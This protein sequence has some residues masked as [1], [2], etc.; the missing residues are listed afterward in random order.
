M[1]MPAFATTI[2]RKSASCAEPNASVSTPNAT[3]ITLNGVS[4]LARTMLAY[5]RL[6]GV[7]SRAGRSASR[8]AASSALSPGAA[9]TG[10][11]TGRVSRAGT[12]P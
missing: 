4:T 3:R 7:S 10:I 8:R 5:E 12:A 1:P 9:A 2:A 11:P 6:D